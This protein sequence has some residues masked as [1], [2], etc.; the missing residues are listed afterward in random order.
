MSAF[1]TALSYEFT[2]SYQHGR[3]LYTL[4]SDLKYVFGD[5]TSP[6]A[7]IV[8]PDGFITDFASIP[9][10]FDLLFKPNGPW[11]PAAALHDFLL[12]NDSISLIALDALFYEAE[13]VLKVN[14]VIARLF[15][16]SVR[17]YHTFIDRTRHRINWMKFERKVK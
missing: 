8:V 5:M 9:W 7:V 2:G 1:I 10:P 12:T 13:L 14:A 4:T 15:Y 16:W 6:V 17:L 11:A 3:P